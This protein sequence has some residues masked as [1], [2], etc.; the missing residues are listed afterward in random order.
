MSNGEPIIIKGGGSITIELYKGYF[1]SETATSSTHYCSNRQITSL[2]ITD[3][4]ANTTQE[5]ALPESG[6]FTIR[7]FHESAD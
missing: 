7:V 1:P 2:T 4:L 5:I 3:D 6:K